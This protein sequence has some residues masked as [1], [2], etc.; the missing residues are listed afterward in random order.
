MWRKN[1]GKFE[2]RDD[3]KIAGKK[4][5]ALQKIYNF[6]KYK[7]IRAALQSG[8]LEKSENYDRNLEKILFTKFIV[9]ILEI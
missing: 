2:T 8:N 3:V 9:L 4:L 5:Y 7:S 6:E 1:N